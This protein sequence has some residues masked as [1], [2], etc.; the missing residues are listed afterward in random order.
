MTEVKTLLL[1]RPEALSRALAKDI[2]TIFTGQARCI[3][4]P[5]MA[6]VPVGKLPDTA[7]FQALLFTSVNGVQ[8]FAAMGGITDRPCYCVGARTADAARNAGL[9]AISANGATADLVA[10]V[11]KDLAPEDGALLYIHG[12]NTAG[13]IAGE[14]SNLGFSVSS[15]VLYQQAECEFSKAT[16]NALENGEVGGLPLYSPLTARRLVKLLVD[17]PTWPT[18]KLTA[19]CISENVAAE[20][21]DLPFECVLVSAIPNGAAMQAL[22]GEYLR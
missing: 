15:E 6:I 12:E 20:V 19:L 7:S 1:T 21:R 18:E 3:I 4:A 2:E 5:L 13:D 16:L 22:I 17:N 9:N 14:L 10:L 11:T 8:T